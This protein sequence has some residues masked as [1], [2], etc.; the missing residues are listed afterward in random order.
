M[1]ALEIRQAL[2]TLGTWTPPEA[3]IA[4][5]EERIDL[6]AMAV[7]WLIRKVSRRRLAKASKSSLKGALKRFFDTVREVEG[8]PEDG[9]VP[10]RCMNRDVVE[11]VTVR[12]MDRY[13]PGTVYQTLAPVLRELWPWLSDQGLDGLRAAPRDVSGLLPR[14]EIYQPPPRLPTVAEV[15]AMISRIPSPRAR[16]AAVLMRA[17]GLRIEQVCHVHGVDFDQDEGS[18]IVRKG[19]SKR[20]QAM[21]RR[22][23]VPTWLVPTLRDL[24]VWRDGVLVGGERDVVPMRSPRNLGTAF[25][26]AWEAGVA[27][28]VV[29]DGIWKPLNRKKA[30]TT[31]VL[32]AVYQAVLEEAGVR[33]GVIDWLVGHAGR[34]TRSTSYTRPSMSKLREAVAHIPPIAW[35]QTEDQSTRR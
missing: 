4:R 11:R 14:N 20:E 22:V 35:D 26:R 2:D 5:P 25:R 16:T 8:L 10:P 19:K 30:S 7:D 31:H 29:R 1:V 21:M 32:R 24:G 18:L 13:A 34:S 6:E 9:P 28:G 33:D 27:D 23:A 3:P 12:L 15:D 17:T